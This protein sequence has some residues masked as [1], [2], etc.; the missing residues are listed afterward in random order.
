MIS[1][2]TWE[3]N[4]E[5]LR[6]AATTEPFELTWPEVRRFHRSDFVELVGRISESQ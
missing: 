3:T 6:W 5:G 4:M 2:E 1:D